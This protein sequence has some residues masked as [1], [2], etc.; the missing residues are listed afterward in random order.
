MSAKLK[1]W[2]TKHLLS[3]I[4]IS[5]ITL[6]FNNSNLFL[7]LA[8]S[9]PIAI[10]GQILDAAGNPA[11]PA[12]RNLTN[13]NEVY[14][15]PLQTVQ[16]G[17]DGR[18][19]LAVEPGVYKFWISTVNHEMASVP[20]YVSETGPTIAFTI[21]LRP[22]RFQLTAGVKIS[23]DWQG[24]NPDRDGKM[25]PQP[26]GT[27]VS[28]VNNGS[29]QLTYQLTDIATGLN[30]GGTMADSYQYDG[31][32]DYRS[33]LK[34]KPGKLKLVFDPAKLPQAEDPD[35]PRVVYQKPY[36]YLEKIFRIAARFDQQSQKFQTALQ[37]YRANRGN[38][39]DFFF[40]NKELRAF[41]EDRM[42][43]EP[44]LAVRQFAALYLGRLSNMNTKLDP[45]VSQEIFSTIPPDS[46]LWDIEPQLIA[47]L[48]NRLT[49]Q[50][51][52]PVLQK[53]VAQNSSRRVQA[54][55]LK[56]MVIIAQNNGE[57][58]KAKALYA[59]LK[60]RYGDLKEV[61]LELVIVNPGPQLEAGKPAPNFTIKLLDNGQTLTNRDLQGKYYLLDFWASWCGGCQAERPLVQEAYQKFQ[62][63]GLTFIS[64]SLDR[65]PEDVAKFRAGKW[66]MPW[67]NAWVD[68]GLGSQLARDFNIKYI[69]KLILVGPD[70]RIIATGAELGGAKL[71]EKLEQYLTAIKK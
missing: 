68:G 36:Q 43:H 5:L 48:C 57:K 58:E 60:G 4:F 35:L 56:D 18:F 62:G 38:P 3:I 40:N 49:G 55:A 54:E 14:Y 31:L 6:I 24:F 52:E 33:S 19:S 7:S 10:Q 22:C 11:G 13:F 30:I 46:R 66:R 39:A 69:P 37:A 23:G 12:Y 71:S 1:P 51:I 65:N 25:Q 64:L 9:G 47:Q 26:D 15:H 59:Q 44:E 53:I 63:R 2:M 61:Q 32:G 8:A 41:L 29:Y 45:A 16:T 70:G 17:P 20:L 42:R 34:V 28:E 67:C 21:R 27:F 50:T